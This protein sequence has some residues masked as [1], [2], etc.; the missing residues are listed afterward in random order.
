MEMW[1][2]KISLEMVG[3]VVEKFWGINLQGYDSLIGEAKFTLVILY[4]FMEL[5]KSIVETTYMS[6]TDYS[7]L[8]S[9]HLE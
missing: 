7:G 6:W 8:M 9:I 3:T 5:Q 2:W 1:S 4:L